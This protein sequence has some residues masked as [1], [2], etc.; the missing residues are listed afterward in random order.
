MCAQSLSYVWLFVTPWTVACQ[1][2]LPMEFSRQEYWSELPFPSPG[3]I[4]D[5]GIKP[6]LLHGRWDSL[7]L[8]HLGGPYL[9]WHPF[10][11]DIWI[12]DSFPIAW[13]NSGLFPWF[14]IGIKMYL[15]IK[16]GWRCWRIGCNH[17]VPLA[18][19][20]YP[21]NVSFLCKIP[22]VQSTHVNCVRILYLGW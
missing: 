10:K 13:F 3:D 8:H 15:G 21:Q 1:A 17:R 20:S 9:T 16:K 2:P 5:P 12:P 18:M 6:H 22:V 4:P 19:K 14:A 11:S 7:P